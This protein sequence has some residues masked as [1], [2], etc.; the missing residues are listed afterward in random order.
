VLTKKLYNYIVE[1]KKEFVLRKKKV[2]LLLREKRKEVW[3]FIEEQLR[4]KYCYMSSPL[5]LRIHYCSGVITI[6]SWR[7]ACLSS[8]TAT[9][10]VTHLCG[11]DTTTGIFS[12]LW[13]SSPILLL[14]VFYHWNLY[15]EQNTGTLSISYIFNLYI[16]LKVTL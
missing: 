2:Y 5:F 10:L 16:K 4:K 14:L 11:S 12:F 6:T 3:K 15:S 7:Q 9:L 8:I 1:T 13:Q